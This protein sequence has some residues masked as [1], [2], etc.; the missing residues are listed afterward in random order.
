VVSVAVTGTPKGP[1]G[2]CHARRSTKLLR[3]P[4]GSARTESQSPGTP[5]A[6]LVVVSATSRGATPPPCI[7]A[8][9]ARTRA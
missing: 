4:R 3:A 2:P 9:A 6:L 1:S 5:V 8:A 7:G